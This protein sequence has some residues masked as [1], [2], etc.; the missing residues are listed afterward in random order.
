MPLIDMSFHRVAVDF[1]GPLQPASNCD[2]CYILTLEDFLLGIKKLSHSIQ[3]VSE[4]L[5]TFILLNWGSRTNDDGSR[6]SI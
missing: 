2:N 4:A 6:Y 5:I 1:I 3:R